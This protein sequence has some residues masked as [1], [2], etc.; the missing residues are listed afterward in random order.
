MLN[1]WTLINALLELSERIQGQFSDFKLGNY[2]LIQCQSIVVSVFYCTTRI[3]THTR[4]CDHITPVL[5]KLHWL[6]I[7]ER[8]VFKNSFIDT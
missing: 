3:V 2:S 5:C 7:E 6:P 4:K 1:P 8:I